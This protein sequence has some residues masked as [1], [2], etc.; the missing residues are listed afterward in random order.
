MS[1]WRYPAIDFARDRGSRRRWHGRL[2]IIVAILVGVEL[3]ALAWRLQSLDA[4]RTA[5][6]EQQ[7]RLRVR[8][9]APPPPPGKELIQQLTGV[10]SML[11]SLSIPWE[12]LL[13]AIEAAKGERIVIESVRPDAK[14][15]TLEITLTTGDFGELRAFVGR[16]GENDFLQA[17]TL[18]S[19]SVD[20]AA[21]S[22]G[23]SGTLRAT[24]SARWQTKG[25]Q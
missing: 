19:E 3:G 24:L 20:L 12:D 5:L 10:R 14:G 6:G 7:Q 1:H 23:A 18:V 25:G 16:L 15:E 21:A 8:R 4:E 22:A 9:D 17:V 2:W 11:G 13:S